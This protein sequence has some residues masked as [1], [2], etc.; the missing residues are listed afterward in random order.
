MTLYVTVIIT[1]SHNI[2][3]NVKNS[4]KIVLY[5]ICQDQEKWT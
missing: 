5:N 2:E 4:K 3:K 1:I